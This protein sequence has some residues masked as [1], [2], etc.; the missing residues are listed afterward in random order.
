MSLTERLWERGIPVTRPV[1]QCDRNPNPGT[2][3]VVADGFIW[4]MLGDAWAS[5]YSTVH[6][7]L[8]R[9]KLASPV[10]SIVP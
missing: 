9:R 10:D 5:P 2:G 3:E 8:K 7:K 6:Q 4:D 1:P